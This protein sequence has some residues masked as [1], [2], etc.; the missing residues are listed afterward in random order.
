M[1]I[2][3]VDDEILAMNYLISLLKK[4]G[5]TDVY[6]FNDS[7]E[8]LEFMK[9]HTINVAFFDIEM[10]VCNGL[11]LTNKC[12]ML[13]P[14]INIIFVTGY[15]K[16]S[17]DALKLHVSGFLMKPARVS[18]VLNELENLR[19]PIKEESENPVFVQTFGNFEVFVKGKPI[20]FSR[21]KS[22]ECLAY[23]VDRRGSKVTTREMASI[24]FE[25][26]AY[27]RALQ[28][29]LHQILHALSESLKMHNL[30]DMLIRDHDGLAIDTKSIVCDYY[31]TMKG[32]LFYLN[33]FMGEYMSNYS[34]AEYTLTE[35]SEK[36][37]SI[38][39]IP[40]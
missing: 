15:S 14:F 2:I 1:E 27:D 20:T 32:N 36:I 5:Y 38:K 30:S 34:W 28:N 18:D 25:D 11:E 10:G 23:L 13:N 19:Y 3:V 24:L 26:C 33:N 17:Y 37:K 40:S 31:A 22:K 39:E 4:I 35:L 6:G 9:S 12:K 29:R 21:S 8:A 16:Y 7:N